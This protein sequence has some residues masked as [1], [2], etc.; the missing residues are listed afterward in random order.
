MIE[1]AIKISCTSTILKPESSDGVIWRQWRLQINPI[2]HASLSSY[3]DHV[4]YFLHE[5]FETPH[6][7]NEMEY[8]KKNIVYIAECYA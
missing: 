3:I 6:I 2:Q 4:E 5:S 8:A 1:K 7:G